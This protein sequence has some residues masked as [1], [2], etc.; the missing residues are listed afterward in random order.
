MTCAELI[1]ATFLAVGRQAQAVYPDTPLRP[2]LEDGP[3][4]PKADAQT[5]PV[6]QRFNRIAT[7][8]YYVRI[9]E[10][11]CKNPAYLKAVVA[12]EFGHMLAHAK[13]YKDSEQLATTLGATLLTD[14]EKQATLS[15]LEE[16]L[17]T[18]HLRMWQYATAK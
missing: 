18:D 14:E 4:L 13:D 10:R 8:R 11:L 2:I 6:T 5:T 12:H 16:N 7:T 15:Y 17:Y 3:V 1:L 9:H